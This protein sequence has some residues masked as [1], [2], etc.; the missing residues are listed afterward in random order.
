MQ[1]KPNMTVIEGQAKSVDPA[2]DGWGETVEFAVEQSGP[3]DGYSDFLKASPGSTVTMFTAEPGTVQPGLSYTVTASVLGGPT[4]ERVVL[5][6]VK[7]KD[8]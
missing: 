7:A 8:R 6:D 1:L 3:A 5:Q 4:G 2:P